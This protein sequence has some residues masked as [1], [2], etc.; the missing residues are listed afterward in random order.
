MQIQSP[1]T[2]VSAVIF[3]GVFFFFFFSSY[4]LHATPPILNQALGL[5]TSNILHPT[6]TFFFLFLSPTQHTPCLN[7][8][9]LFIRLLF[10]SNF[11]YFIP[12][13]SSTASCCHTYH[14]RTFFLLHPYP[15]PYLYPTLPY[16]YSTL[17]QHPPN[18]ILIMAYCTNRKHFFP[19][20]QWLLS[21]RRTSSSFASNTQQM[22][23]NLYD[24][25]NR[26]LMKTQWHFQ[27][28]INQ[29]RIQVLYILLEWKYIYVMCPKFRK[30]IFRYFHYLSSL[31]I[32]YLYFNL[33]P[34]YLPCFFL[35]VLLW[36]RFFHL[37]CIVFTCFHHH[38]DKVITVK[39]TA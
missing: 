1:F 29:S 15:Y 11:Y 26:L 25:I 13:F 33:H 3:I 30:L 35:L 2:V 4:I 28:V 34:L 27:I 10:P 19:S 22:I 14:M 31:L 39:I 37:N 6:S 7:L 36:R 32:G 17:S 5:V 23:Y 20:F 8:L 24:K 18:V 16:R 12:C 38:I 9:Y 21:Y